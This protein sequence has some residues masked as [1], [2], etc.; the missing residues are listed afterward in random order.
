MT[1]TFVVDDMRLEADYSVYFPGTGEAPADRRSGVVKEK[2]SLYPS[3]EY[4]DPH[5]D[6]F[7]SSLKAIVNI[8]WIQTNQ[9][10]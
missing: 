7:I 8:P 1:T 3:Y 6:T 5:Y 2:V 4:T 9:Y 10:F